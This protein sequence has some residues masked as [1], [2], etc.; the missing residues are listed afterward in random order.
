MRWVVYVALMGKGEAKTGFW[1]GNRREKVPWV[2]SGVDGSIMLRWIYVVH[3]RCNDKIYDESSGS[4]MW[5]YGL[6]WAEIR[7]C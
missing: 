1:C 7:Y 4:G 3:T 5:R 6:D 2:E